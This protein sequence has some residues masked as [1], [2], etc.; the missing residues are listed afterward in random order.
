MAVDQADWERAKE[1]L[2]GLGLMPADPGTIGD[3]AQALT[4]ARA[5]GYRDAA[6]TSRTFCSRAGGCL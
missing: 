2:D 5:E 3:L 1:L 4:D 6:E